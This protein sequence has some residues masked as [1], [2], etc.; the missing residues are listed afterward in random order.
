[1]F[2][3]G[4][5]IGGDFLAGGW[6]RVRWPPCHHAVTPPCHPHWVTLLSPHLVMLSL[7]IPDPAVP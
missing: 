6:E 5:E 2:L 1:M 7:I 3:E 4:D